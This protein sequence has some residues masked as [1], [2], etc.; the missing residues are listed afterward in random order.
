MKAILN[1]FVF[2]IMCN[3]FAQE[4]PNFQAVDS[5]YRE[6]QFYV[7]ITYNT[8]QKLP[9]GINQNKFTPSFSF[10]FLRDIPVNKSRTW[11]FAAGLG[12]AINNYNQNVLISE[13]TF[14]D[15][16]YAILN[17]SYDKNKLTLHY[18]DLPIEIRWRN[19]TPQ[20]HKFWRIYSGFKVSY[21]IFDKSKYKDGGNKIIVV[22]NSDLN[23]L[24]YGAYLSA[25]NNTLNFFAYYSLNNTF[26]SGNL[27]NNNEKLNL[28][29]L[30]IGLMFYIL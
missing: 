12:Y 3:L 20:S 2:F 9:R 22:G 15:P 11:A 30:N 25:G 23:K 8:L 28:R 1:V 6:D 29:T 13:T 26:K 7:G 16:S 19:S 27:I 10:G 24:Q 17:S 5:L 14:G 18:L 4:K 21:L